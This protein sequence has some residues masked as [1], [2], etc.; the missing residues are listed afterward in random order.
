MAVRELHELADNSVSQFITHL[1]KVTTVN[2]F[3]SMQIHICSFLIMYYLMYT[4]NECIP[5]INH[6]EGSLSHVTIEI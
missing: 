5:M 2:V 4:H 1:N 3:T 6:N